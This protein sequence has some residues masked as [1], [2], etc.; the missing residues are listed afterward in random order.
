MDTMYVFLYI[1]HVTEDVA[2]KQEVTVNGTIDFYIDLI[3]PNNTCMIYKWHVQVEG[4]NVD[5]T[6]N[7][8][9]LDEA[10]GDYLIISPGK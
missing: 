3:P 5:V 8:L 10:A 7:Y 4:Y 6:V 1:V 2:C 9:D